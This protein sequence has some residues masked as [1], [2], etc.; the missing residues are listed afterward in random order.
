MSR[1]VKVIDRRR[2]VG[3]VG[4]GLAAA[5]AGCA[6]PVG[7]PVGTPGAAPGGTGSPGP[8]PAPRPWSWEIRYIR[9]TPKV[10][11]SRWKLVIGGL[12]AAPLELSLEA[13]R[14]LPA[15]EFLARMKCV[16]CWSGPA[17]WR[18][19]AGADL[20]G[21]VTALPAATHVRL[22]ALDGYDTTLPLK[23]ITAARSLFVHTMDGAPLP[24]DNGF[25][26]RLMIP[27]L[28]GYKNIK[29]I[30]RLEFTD[31]AI[32]GYWARN[33]YPD[34]GGIRAGTDHPLDLGGSRPIKGGEITDY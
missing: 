32:L 11:P 21:Q 3:M 17:L 18:G 12:V 6:G 33:G 22:V 16:E 26:L 14:A 2:F 20:L 10:D 34:D 13:L 23:V 30:E 28:Y 24:P 9:G 25:P 5:A 1:A 15:T 29:G 19:V 31:R 8:S 7:T 4:L 27:S